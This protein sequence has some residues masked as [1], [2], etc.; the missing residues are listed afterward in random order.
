MTVDSGGKTFDVAR[1]PM[2]KQALAAL[3]VLTVL[4]CHGA[5][6]AMHQVMA[7]PDPA[8]HGHVAQVP[9]AGNGG[10]ESGGLV[11]HLAALLFPEQMMAHAGDGGAAA[12]L[13]YGA[14]L[15]FVSALLLRLLIGI[16]LRWCPRSRPGLSLLR[17]GPR[18]TG[19]CPPP[20]R[21]SG[22]QV[23]RL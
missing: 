19:R 11:S 2:G 3:L 21:I 14:A 5:Y 22:L 10:M 4:I 16:P 20:P 7:D 13:A 17:R 15:I 6:G 12:I 18:A 23:F 9:H 1:E 8:M